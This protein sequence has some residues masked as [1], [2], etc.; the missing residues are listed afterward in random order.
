MITANSS[1]ILG[2]QCD[3]IIIQSTTCRDNYYTTCET[4]IAN[5]A[6]LLAKCCITIHKTSEIQHMNNA[7]K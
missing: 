5:A 1:A 6:Q 7:N 4:S 3:E 2:P